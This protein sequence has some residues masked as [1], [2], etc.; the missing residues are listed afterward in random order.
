LLVAA[1][2]GGALT[3]GSTV[4]LLAVLGVAARQQLALLGELQTHEPDDAPS[5]RLER[6]VAATRARL[7][8]ILT[9]LAAIT[10]AM[11][12]IVLAGFAAG[13]EVVRPTALVIIGGSL[14]ASLV[15][16][17]LVPALYLRVARVARVAPRE[18]ELGK[19]VYG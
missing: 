6:V 15:T 8:V 9:S 18:V 1:S 12:P 16:T 17:L 3:L 19:L 2:L 4:G 14:I 10:V 5:L 11:L 7:P 13:L